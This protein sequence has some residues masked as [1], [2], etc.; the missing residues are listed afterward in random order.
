MQRLD[1][2]LL[3]QILTA[4]AAFLPQSTWTLLKGLLFLVQLF[5]Q[6]HLLTK[7]GLCGET[8]QMALKDG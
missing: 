8:N 3:R 1:V 2:V 5:Y 6:F 7:H 4:E